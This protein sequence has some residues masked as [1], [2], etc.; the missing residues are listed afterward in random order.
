M[1][2]AI[3]RILVLVLLIFLGLGAYLTVY[4]IS[5]NEMGLVYN[6]R[7]KKLVTVFKKPYNFVWQ[8]GCPVF[9]SIEK[10]NLKRSK[11]FDLKIPLP[12]LENIKSDF[13]SLKFPVNLVYQLDQNSFFDYQK[14]GDGSLGLEAD[15]KKILEGSW[16][17]Y[18]KSYFVP[19]YLRSKII[20]DEDLLFKKIFSYLKKELQLIG[21]NLIKLN[22]VGEI[23]YPPK[24]IY[25]LGFFHLDKMRKIWEDEQGQM[26]LLHNKFKRD[27][28]ANEEL[29]QKLSKMTEIIRDN[30]D[31]LKYL[32]IDK[33]ADKV[34]VLISPNNL[35]IP[36]E[37]GLGRDNSKV[38]ETR[39]ID[40]LK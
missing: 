38:P 3:G 2:K 32:Y 23:P 20:K 15:L 40:N 14:L 11:I 35:E 34:K 4:K 16:S 27:R 5:K 22:V 26:T 24:K 1:K 12:L 30:P 36:F 8:G 39:E 9:F 25:E 31:I 17:K 19:V 7:T 21:I 29:Y 33:I 28:L 10:I 13:Y 6:L 18:L 37:T